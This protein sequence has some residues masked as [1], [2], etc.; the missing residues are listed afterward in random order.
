MQLGTRNIRSAG[1]GS[2]SIEVTLP[3]PL[4]DLAGLPCMIALRDGLR[5][6]IVLAPDLRPARE[7]LARLWTLMGEALGVTLGALPLGTI[8][9]ALKPDLALDRLSWSDALALAAPLPHAPDALC[10]I[11]RA[12]AVH[13][14]P[15]LGLHDALAGGFGAALAFTLTGRVA[16]PGDQE[17]CDITATLCRPPPCGFGEDAFAL[18]LWLACGP[19]L[20]AVLA[21]H[22]DFCAHPERLDALRRAWRQGVALELNGD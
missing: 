7:A 20:R 22:L 6:E 9:I 14:A 4:R 15:Q 17:A 2:G 12:M 1:Q 10:R 21:L 18:A 13:A 16:A 19:S 8:G 11:T 3:S 5:P